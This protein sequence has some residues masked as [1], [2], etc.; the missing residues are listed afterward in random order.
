MQELNNE[1]PPME[2]YVHHTDKPGEA[3]LPWSH[4]QGPLPEG[5]L[6]KHAETAAELML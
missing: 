3:V 1:L 6:I 2:Y 5:T 4:L